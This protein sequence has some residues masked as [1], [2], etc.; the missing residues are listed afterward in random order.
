[1][2]LLAITRHPRLVD[3]LRTAF[4]GAGHRIATVPDPIQALAQDAW[5]RARL[6]VV[7]AE[8]DPM[9]GYQLC[10]LLRGESSLL[11]RNL[12]IF[13][14][15]DH[16]PEAE[17]R[18]GLER[19]DGDGF[20]ELDASIHELQSLLGP[21]LEGSSLRNGGL[22][23]PVL[24]HG[25]PKALAA[26]VGEVV[27]SFGF[28]LHTATRKELRPVLEALR[29]PLLFLGVDAKGAKALE[30]LRT[31]PGP[32]PPYTILVGGDVPE[33]VQR[34]L[35][36]AGAMDWIPLP[37]SGPLLLHATRRALEWAHVQ[38]LKLEY[39]RQLNDLAE[40]REALEREASALRS[41]VLTDSLTELLNR[42]AFNQHL[43]HAANQWER[44]RRAFVLILGDLD[45]F[46]LINDR[47]GHLAGDQVLKGVGARIR[48]GLRRSD[49]AFRIGGE[50]FAILLSETTLAAGVD[51]AEKIRRRIEATPMTLDTGQM[52][53]PTVS[54]GVGAPD[55]GMDSANLFT[56]VDEALYLAKRMGRNRVE[57]MA[58]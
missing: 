6:V 41:E 21:L 29:P 55:E 53:F 27:R 15:L 19:V 22:P 43:G 8:G 24:A 14:A 2:D 46:K 31:L 28:E 5:D 11:Y 3:A 51:V 52:V 49:L 38:R 17:D 56:K 44:H 26:K 25:L 12:P 48:A 54:F 10:G 13:L 57:V 18:A 47:F 23:V 33:G 4:E 20:V 1:M 36:T 34:K 50:E 35:L 9:N 30:T 7:D 32:Q 37:L 16:P 42:R 40:R 45:Y 39:Q 58:P